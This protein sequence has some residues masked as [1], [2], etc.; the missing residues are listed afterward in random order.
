MDKSVRRFFL[1]TA[2]AG[3][4]LLATACNQ[5]TSSAHK[6]VVN[7][8]SYT[9]LSPAASAELNQAMIGQL[10][11]LATSPWGDQVTLKILNRYFA[12]SGLNCLQALVEVGFQSPTV[13]ICEYPEQGWGVTRD[14][15]GQQ[16]LNN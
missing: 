11:T 7:S 10:R 16:A 3:C 9:Q 14:L 8:T 13:V 1:F 2:I 5:L 15:R 12:A 4:T 6:P